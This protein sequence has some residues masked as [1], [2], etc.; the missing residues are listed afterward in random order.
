MMFAVLMICAHLRVALAMNALK[1]SLVLPRSCSPA[2]SALRRTS[3][4][5][6]AALISAFSRATMLG[7]VPAGGTV[8]RKD[9]SLLC[10]VRLEHAAD[11]IARGGVQRLKVG[12]QVVLPSFGLFFRRDGLAQPAVLAEFAHAMRSVSG[13]NIPKI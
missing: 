2:A 12:P 11:E 9:P 4:S 10:A 8:L 3:A 7:G 1:S 5:V 6:T 13:A